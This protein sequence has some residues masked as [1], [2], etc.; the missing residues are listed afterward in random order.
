MTHPYPIANNHTGYPV[1]KGYWRDRL[2]QL[3][4]KLIYGR[5]WHYVSPWQHAGVCTSAICVHNG[6]ILLGRR[7]GIEQAG[8]LSHLGGHVNL[9]YQ[10]G[11]LDSLVREIQE[12]TSMVIPAKQV[13]W[14]DLCDISLNYDVEYIML[15]KGTNI[16]MS[17]AIELTDEQVSQ[18]QD[19]AEAHD[20]GFYSLEEIQAFKDSGELAFSDLFR[21]CHAALT[22]LDEQLS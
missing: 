13:N 8:K 15:G 14:A 17:F 9:E 22:H 19:S 21:I 2:A 11:L 18:I 4:L 20:F 7:R 16:S 6:R 3:C 10:E 5:P 1:N 12:E